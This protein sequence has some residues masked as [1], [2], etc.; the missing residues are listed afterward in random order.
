MIPNLLI[1]AALE[2]EAQWMVEPGQTP[3]TRPVVDRLPN[4]RS[5]VAALHAY[6]RSA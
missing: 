6:R 5:Y 2:A 3:T 4:V 1:A